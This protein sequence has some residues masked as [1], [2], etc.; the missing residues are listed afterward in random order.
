V[1]PA[2]RVRCH[3][4]RRW[5]PA[6][7]SWAGNRPP[8]QHLV[9]GR[10]RYPLER[11]AARWVTVSPDDAAPFARGPLWNKSGGVIWNMSTTSARHGSHMPPI[12]P[13]RSAA[14]L[15]VNTRFV[16]RKEN[17][18]EFLTTL[19][20]CS[21]QNQEGASGTGRQVPRSCRMPPLVEGYDYP[22]TIAGYLYAGPSSRKR[23]VGTEEGKRRG[24]TRSLPS[25][26]LAR[27][28]PFPGG[29]SPSSPLG[30]G[31]R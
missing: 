4:L 20:T 21:E 8:G 28:R 26:W 27:V 18:P 11:V 30:L 1:T 10:R 29:G 16:S 14:Y 5:L 19:S 25:Q 23:D 7:W 3:P 9:R 17:E 12:I 13:S 15:I 2:P 24:S 31:P 22:S 6:V